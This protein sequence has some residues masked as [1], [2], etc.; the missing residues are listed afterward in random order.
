M[1]KNILLLAFFYTVVL[2]TAKSTEWQDTTP[3]KIYYVEMDDKIKLEV[4]DWGGE[5]TPLVF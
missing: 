4:V 2:N 3:H 5:G 1:I